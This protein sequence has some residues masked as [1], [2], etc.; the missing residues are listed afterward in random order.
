[1]EDLYLHARKN[2]IQA[3]IDYLSLSE[4]VIPYYRDIIYM[5]LSIIY[6]DNPTEMNKLVLAYGT[7]IYS[8]VLITIGDHINGRRKCHDAMEIMQTFNMCS[9]LHKPLSPETFDFLSTLHNSTVSNVF[10]DYAYEN[11]IKIKH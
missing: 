8:S 2:N 3:I 4:Y 6:D 10:K 5:R 11:V 1:M 7:F 9:S